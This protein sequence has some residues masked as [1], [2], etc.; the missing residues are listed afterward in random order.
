[1]L[2]IFISVSRP[3]FV[4]MPG[5]H[6]TA[7]GAARSLHQ[8]ARQGVDQELR[9]GSVR[10]CQERAVLSEEGTRGWL[11]QQLFFCAL[12]GELGVWAQMHLVCLQGK[13][14]DLDMKPYTLEDL[15]F[16][17]RAISDIRDMSLT[18]EST[19][20]D[21]DER[22]RVLVVYDLCVSVSL[23]SEDLNRQI[24]KCF[25]TCLFPTKIFMNTLLQ[26]KLE[27]RD[28]VR[29]LPTMWDELVLKS[30]NVDA[31]L[32]TVKRK[33]TEVKSTFQETVQSS[34]NQTSRWMCGCFSSRIFSD[35]PEADRRVR[36]E[37][38]EIQA[39][40]QRGGTWSCW[41]SPGHRSGLFRLARA[42]FEP[43]FGCCGRRWL[44]L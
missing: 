30:K 37:F 28:L 16:I 9:T 7:H 6:P 38:E 29:T 20:R 23:F 31:S 36:S 41:G 42:H 22:Y 14:D 33:F 39:A 27:E 35:H 11:R 40:V 3:L 44:R 24:N 34:L 4:P 5:L 13:S 26:P 25:R 43:A 17:L 10:L 12:S 1:M 15:K 2:R 32:I 19:A 21:L 18:V 8:A